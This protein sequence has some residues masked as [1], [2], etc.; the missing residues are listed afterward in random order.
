[1]RIQVRLMGM[2]KSKTPADNAIELDVGANIADALRALEIPADS[3]HVF[4]LNGQLVRDRA[5]PLNAG[6]ELSILPPVGGG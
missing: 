2:L 6:D 4:T 5:Q 1:M 3:A